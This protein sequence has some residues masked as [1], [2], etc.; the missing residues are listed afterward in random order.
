M[1]ITKRQLRRIIKEEAQYFRQF[2]GE[3]KVDMVA[4]NRAKP[5]IAD[6]VDLLLDELKNETPQAENIPDEKR[7]IM[8]KAITDG[9]WKV[10][11]DLFAAHV[12]ME[13]GAKRLGEGQIIRLVTRHVL[14]EVLTGNIQRQIIRDSRPG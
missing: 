3:Y 12:P 10:L 7:D 8:I 4:L 5:I 13:P 1:R 9:V 14:R 11:P 6:W 2:R